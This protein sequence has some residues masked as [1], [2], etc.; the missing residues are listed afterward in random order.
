MQLT[1]EERL[2]LLELAEGAITHGARI[3]DVPPPD[4]RCVRF[5]HRRHASFVTVHVGGALNGCIGSLEPMQSLG[6]DV[7]Q[8]A[9]RAAFHD[10]RFPCVR[11]SDLEHV[12]IHVSILGPLVEMSVADEEDLVSRL[13]PE[14]DGLVLRAGRRRGTFLPSVWEKVSGPEQFVSFLKRKAGIDALEWPDG[15]E[16]FK[17]G[18]EEFDRERLTH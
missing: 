12:G 17:F 14:I 11:E 10:P 8:H 15:I 3:G 2:A 5:S 6:E 9:Y 7:V 18:V 1:V 4:E 13:R 16:V